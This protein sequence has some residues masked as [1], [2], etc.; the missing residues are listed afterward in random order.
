MLWAGQGK[1]G[2][3]GG[4]AWLDPCAGRRQGEGGACVAGQGVNFVMNGVLA[5]RDLLTP[6]GQAQ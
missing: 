2:A 1:S 3:F 6:A 4:R 5:S